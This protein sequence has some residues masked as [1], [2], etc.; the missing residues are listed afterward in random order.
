MRLPS[1]HRRSS[2]VW[3]FK[4]VTARLIQFWA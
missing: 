1:M 4:R 3:I 2:I